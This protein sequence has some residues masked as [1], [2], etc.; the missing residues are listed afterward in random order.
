MTKNRKFIQGRYI[1]KNIKKYKGDF[2]NI[3]FRSLW[4]YHLFKWLD[5]SSKVIEWGSET[6]AIPY[7]NPY[8]GAFHRYFVDIYAKII[9]RDG[10]TR[11]Y[12]IEVK[13]YNQTIPSKRGN[14]YN[15][16]YNIN[17][18]KWKAAEK[19]AEKN[20]MKFIILTEKELYGK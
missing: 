7:Q 12:L 6:V 20:G 1:P 16:T 9:D 11:K 19:V 8:T 2:R 17:M 10:N 3:V 18:A 5:S 14:K 4:E 13:P 15:M